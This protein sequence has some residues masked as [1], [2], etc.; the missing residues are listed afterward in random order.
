[1]I[2]IQSGIQIVNSVKFRIVNRIAPGWSGIRH[3]LFGGASTLRQTPNLTKYCTD[4][5]SFRREVKLR[6][7]RGNP[8]Y[9]R[10]A[11]S[12]ACDRERTAAAH[13]GTELASSLEE[14][15]KRRFASCVPPLTPVWPAARDHPLGRSG[16]TRLTLKQR[17]CS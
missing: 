5:P 1:M 11:F 10:Q 13:G 9:G 6:V 4:A 16:S 3:L 15:I 12:Q 7:R 17:T 8:P 14:V 2:P